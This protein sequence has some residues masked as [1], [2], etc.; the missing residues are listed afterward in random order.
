MPL[1]RFKDRRGL[2]S[3]KTDINQSTHDALFDEKVDGVM[4]TLDKE[5]VVIASTPP[6]WEFSPNVKFEN[7]LISFGHK[8][9][10]AGTPDKYQGIAVRK[11]RGRWIELKTP[12]Y[13]TWQMAKEDLIRSIK[14]Y[15]KMPLN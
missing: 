6:Q 9:A 13:A 14:A 15:N 2:K 3:L 7:F 10:Y 1:L 5:G 12:I 11:D 8:E 4:R